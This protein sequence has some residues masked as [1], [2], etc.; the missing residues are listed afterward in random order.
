MMKLLGTNTSPYVRKVRLVLL[1]K[2]IPHAYLVDPPREPGSQV[3]RANPLGRIPA[4]ILDDGTCVFDS[5]VIA[6]YIDSLNDAPILIPHANAL[7][8]MRVK[9]WEALADGIMDSA[10]A[11]RNEVLRQADQQNTEAVARHNDAIGRALN[12]A[13]GQL[14]QRE[15]CEGATVTLADLALVSALI[16]LDLR[17]ADRDWRGAHPSLAAWFVRLGARASVRASLA[18]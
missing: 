9:R 5:P 7:E 12:H 17:Q 16:Y 14:G 3:A 2:N 4:L 6:E 1:E 11:V 18:E 13:S 8:R 15:W 10:V